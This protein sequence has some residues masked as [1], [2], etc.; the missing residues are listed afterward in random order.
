MNSCLQCL[1]AVPELDG[2]RRRVPLRR[3]RGR[4]A[5][6]PRRSHARS[7]QRNEDCHVGGDALPIPRPPPPAVPSVC[8]GGPGCLRAAGRRECWSRSRTLCAR[9]PRW[10]ICSPSS[11]RCTSSPRR[12]RG[13]PERRREHA[14]KCNIT[15]DVNHLAEDPKSRWR[16]TSCDRTSPARTWCSRA[17]ASWRNFRRCLTC[18]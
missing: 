16:R 4:D 3:T 7:V 8:A 17:R 6:R 10:T 14:M 2:A 5:A 12:R 9:F 18:T 11:S 1:Y 15:I 13:A